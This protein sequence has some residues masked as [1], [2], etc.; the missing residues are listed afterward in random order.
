MPL[1][2]CD[3]D[4]LRD[5]WLSQ[6][7]FFRPNRRVV[8]LARLCLLFVD[9]DTYRRAWSQGKTPKRQGEALLYFCDSEGI[10]PPSLVVFSGRGLQAKWL[11]EG[12]IPRQV[13]PRWNACQRVLVEALA[14]AGA[15]PWAKDASRVLRLVNTVNTKS[16]NR[17]EVVHVTESSGEVI[18]YGFEYMCEMLLPHFRPDLEKRRL[19]R[20]KKIR[21][22]KRGVGKGNFSGK[23][24]AWD[25]LEDLRKLGEMRGGIVEGERML[26]LFWQLNFLLLSGVT[27]SGQVW[28]EAAALAKELDPKWGYRSVELSTLYQK[29]KAHEAGNRI[30]FEGRKYSPLYTPKNDTLI[31]LFRISSSEQRELRTLIGPEIARERDEKRRRASGIVER[32]EYLEKIGKEDQRVE[33]VDLRDRGWS[34]RAIAEK[35]GISRGRVQQYLKK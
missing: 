10:P 1:V 29:A 3:L 16:G 7:E 20:N 14:E 9:V 2:L 6:A 4:P 12:T 19:G 25:R 33:A 21:E 11:L 23:K 30:E 18:R 32:R 17:C 31:D 8:N 34:Q 5:T 22:R 13:L 24:L 26:H 35:L 27:S 15:D 28:H